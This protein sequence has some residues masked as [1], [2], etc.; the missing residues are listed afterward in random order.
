MDLEIPRE[1]VRF[2]VVFRSGDQ[3]HDLNRVLTHFGLGELDCD[4]NHFMFPVSWPTGRPY[5]PP[6]PEI[7]QH[8]IPWDEDLSASCALNHYGKVQEPQWNSKVGAMEKS[9]SKFTFI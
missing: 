9:T 8:W 7:T 1:E 2:T 5:D 6:L 3:G 4:I